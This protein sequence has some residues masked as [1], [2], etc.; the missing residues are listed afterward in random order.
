MSISWLRKKL[1]LLGL[2][3]C[4]FSFQSY[5]YDNF[6]VTRSWPV[7][8][9]S[10]SC[11]GVTI[12]ASKTRNF[13]TEAL[14]CDA[15]SDT[16]ARDPVSFDEENWRHLLATNATAAKDMLRAL[17]VPE[18]S[19]SFHYDTYLKWSW[20]DCQ[21]VTSHSCGSTRV[22]KKVKSSGIK[23]EWN[24]KSVKGANK[25]DTAEIEQCHD[26]PK[27]CFMDVTISESSHCSK[28]KMTYDVQ[29]QQ[30]DVS[31]ES[32]PARLA[33]GYDLLPGEQENVNVA[34][35]VGLLTNTFMSPNLSF[36]EPYNKYLI[37]RVQ[38]VGYDSDSLSCKKDT[39]Y[40]VGFTVQ[41]LQRIQASSGN[42][43]SLPET[44]DGQPLDPLVWQRARTSEGKWQEKAVPAM[45]R[46]QD[47]SATALNEFALDANTPFKNMVVR[48]QL[49]DKSALAWPFARNT[50]YVNEAKAVAQTFNAL[51]DKQKVRRSRLWELLL[52][53]NSV[54]PEKNLYRSYIPWVVYYPSRLLF[55]ADE[56]S[57][58]N[59]ADTGN[60]LSA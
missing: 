29:Y 58:E 60:R 41:P 59:Q 11:P 16:K 37:N 17:P 23:K 45:L 21:L 38:G 19:G 6:C 24:D 20:E 39:T 36:A 14:H 9:Y 34:N 3:Q 44:F 8:R 57:Y 53:A 42:A 13:H 32:Y 22:C 49:Y 4:F 27:T 12:P 7:E 2:L 30:T 26:E 43:F 10:A 33:N 1:F 31:D 46:V 54:N 18:W 51:S 40:H 15:G 25:I 47:Y 28:E 55:P 35:G 5:G 50:I 48:I 56:L 52:A